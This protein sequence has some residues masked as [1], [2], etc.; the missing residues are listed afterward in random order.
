MILLIAYLVMQSTLSIF[1]VCMFTVYLVLS[2]YHGVFG[3]LLLLFGRILLPYILMSLICCFVVLSC[4]WLIICYGT[5]LARS[6]DYWYLI[7][8]GYHVTVSSL[9]FLATIWYGTVQY[10]NSPST[11]KQTFSCHYVVLD[12][13]HLVLSY[14][15]VPPA[16]RVAEPRSSSVSGGGSGSDLK[17]V[18]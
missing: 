8:T 7:G 11:I 12:C 15:L 14:Y 6:W 3:P 10:R 2:C 9:F 4:F 13:Y 17:E 18:M 5:F 1:C 16:T